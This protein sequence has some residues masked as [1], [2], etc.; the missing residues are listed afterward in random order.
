[1]AGV[2]SL[3]QTSKLALGP[4]QHP[5][6]WVL[7]ALSSGVRDWGMKVTTLTSSAE[8]KNEL[9]YAPTPQHAFMVNTGTTLPL[10]YLR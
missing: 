6:Q 9:K 10:L 7:G 1:M 2:F 8:M 5:A 3:L 4:M